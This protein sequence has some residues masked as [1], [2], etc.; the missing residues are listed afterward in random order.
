MYITISKLSRL[1]QIFDYVEVTE[2]RRE[3]DLATKHPARQSRKQRDLTTKS[4]KVQKE[5]GGR[6]FQPALDNVK[7]FVRAAQLLKHSC[8][9]G[10]GAA[11]V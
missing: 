9:N 11:F 4:P 7:K 3:F 2:F 10:Y 8:T 5:N 6:V 1:P